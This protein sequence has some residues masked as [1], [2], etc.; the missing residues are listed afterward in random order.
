MRNPK[1]E[2]RDP[3]EVRS[4]KSEIGVRRI[5]GDSASVLGIRISFGFRPSDFGTVI[6]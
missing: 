4:P 3:K 6:A 2:I 1:L 5:Q